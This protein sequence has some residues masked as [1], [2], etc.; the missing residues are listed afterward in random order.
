[1]N[2]DNTVTQKAHPVS[3]GTGKRGIGDERQGKRKKLNLKSI[4]EGESKKVT[5]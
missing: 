1:M 5:I 4:L 2:V 3:N